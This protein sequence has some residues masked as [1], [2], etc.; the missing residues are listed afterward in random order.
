M[1][2][3]LNFKTILR[4]VGIIAFAA[5]IVFSTTA[6]QKEVDDS[7][8]LYGNVSITTPWY[9]C[10]AGEELTAVYDGDENVTI[11][12]TW[13]LDNAEVGTGSKYTP[14]AAG[15][16]Y[17]K[18]SADGYDNVKESDKIQVNSALS[19]LANKP[20]LGWS[21]GQTMFIFKPDGALFM[22]VT[23]ANY[24][25]KGT[26]TI[27]GNKV[28]FI[29]EGGEPNSNTWS[30]T[31]DA[32]TLTTSAATYTLK[33]S[34]VDKGWDN[35]RELAGTSFNI[36]CSQEIGDEMTVNYNGSETITAYQ[37]KKVRSDNA[38]YEI[39]GKESTYTPTTAGKYI[40]TIIADGYIGKTSQEVEVY[41]PAIPGTV[42][43]SID[44]GKWVVNK[45]ITFTFTPS[46]PSITITK[47]QWENKNRIAIEGATTNKYTPTLTG[48]YYITIYADATK[49][50]ENTYG[51]PYDI[52]TTAEE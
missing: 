50:R 45:E 8:Y 19:P 34:P 38:G 7:Q 39:V 36:S 51:I 46:D 28:Q 49:Y 33:S 12:F 52:A 22:A 43:F 3:T 20:G 48:K 30:I 26:Y 29:V 44:G 17:V 13:V 18:A 6:C 40:V 35:L 15:Q 47:Y 42:S 4:I 32:L 11:N 25:F 24:E 2:N 5:V 9:G 16:L 21:D 41:L 14:T 10:Y 31:G 27:T 23:Y 37:W 1:K